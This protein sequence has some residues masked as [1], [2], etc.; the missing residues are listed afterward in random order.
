MI[1]VWQVLRL[2]AGKFVQRYVLK[3]KATSR[4]EQNIV[5]IFRWDCCLITIGFWYMVVVVPNVLS[6][7]KKHSW[8]PCVYIRETFCSLLLEVDPLY[9]NWFFFFFNIFSLMSTNSDFMRWANCTGCGIIIVDKLLLHQC[10]WGKT[11]LIWC[12]H[13]SYRTM[14]SGITEL[15]FVAAI[16]GFGRG[17]KQ[18]GFSSCKPKCFITYKLIR[19]FICRQ[20]AVMLSCWA[21]SNRWKITGNYRLNNLVSVWKRKIIYIAI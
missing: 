12:D 16:R 8:P 13:R 21:L 2:A 3:D 4:L 20:I 11:N 18:W 1:L 19:N 17:G 14:R 10:T 9:I 5:S 15:G 6:F 7:S